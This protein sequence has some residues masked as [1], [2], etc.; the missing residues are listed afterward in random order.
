MN[1]RLNNK[2]RVEKSGQ[3]RKDGTYLWRAFN[4]SLRSILSI[5]YPCQRPNRKQ[6]VHS[7]GSELKKKNPK[8]GPFTRHGQGSD[9]LTKDD[10]TALSQLL[11]EAEANKKPDTKGPTGTVHTVRFPGYKVKQKGQGRSRGVQRIS[12]TISV[13]VRTTKCLCRELWDYFYKFRKT[14]SLAVYD[15]RGNMMDMGKPTKKHF[16]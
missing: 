6:K 14:D 5:Y 12:S 4:A 16:E 2:I 8:R 13:S 11:Q 1:L 15:R 10:Q 3:R 7:K 9:K